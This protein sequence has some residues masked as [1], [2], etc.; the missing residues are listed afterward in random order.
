MNKRLY[1]ASALAVWLHA[2]V[3]SSSAT[4]L[5]TDSALIVWYKLNGSGTSASNSAPGGGHTGT[6]TGGPPTY[7]AVGSQFLGGGV[8][9][10]AT[11]SDRIVV[12]DDN[13]LTPG[14]QTV[15]LWFNADAWSANYMTLAGKYDD[16]PYP[17]WIIR[18]STTN[19]IEAFLWAGNYGI[20]S[21]SF[22]DT[23]S[24]HH[25]A[26]TYGGSGDSILR[27]YLDGAEVGTADTTPTANLPGTDNNLHIG[28][29]V[30]SPSSRYFDGQIADFRLYSR[31]LTP[32]EVLRLYNMQF[33]SVRTM[34]HARM[35]Q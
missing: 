32:A 19:S 25:I 28:G 12:A 16:N 13:A 27:L 30:V 33:Q 23:E 8:D 9:F 31:P 4:N 6:L 35:G 3:A 7:L 34:Y 18:R 1:M 24:W 22:S 11:N 15:A 10:V 5:N 26:I 29:D 21:T 2:A 14:A 17:G 20:V